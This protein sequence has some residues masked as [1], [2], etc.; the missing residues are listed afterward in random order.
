MVARLGGIGPR[1]HGCTYRIRAVYTNSCWLLDT[2]CYAFIFGGLY[3]WFFHHTRKYGVALLLLVV[4]ILGSFV[5][6]LTIG[7]N[8]V[9]RRMANVL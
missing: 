6:Y 8:A 1:E 9:H 5:I 4:W 7:T 3:S 2:L